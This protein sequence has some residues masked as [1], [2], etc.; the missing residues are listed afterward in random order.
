MHFHSPSAG[1]YLLAGITV[2][3]AALIAFLGHRRSP[4]A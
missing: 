3:N 2:A 4:K 1:L